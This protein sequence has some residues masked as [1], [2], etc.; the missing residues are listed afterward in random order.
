MWAKSFG[1]LTFNRQAV[2][3]SKRNA[4]SQR[5]KKNLEGTVSQKTMG[6]VITVDIFFL[7]DQT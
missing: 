5:Q 6:K 2:K 7:I 3:R 1:T 4:Q